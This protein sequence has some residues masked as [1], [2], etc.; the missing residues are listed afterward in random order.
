MNVLL[1]FTHSHVILTSFCETENEML[2]F[3]STELFNTIYIV[4]LLVVLNIK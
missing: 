1:A 4:D 2:G 3:F